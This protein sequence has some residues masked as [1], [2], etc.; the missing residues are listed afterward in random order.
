MNKPTEKF[1]AAFKWDDPFLLDDQL[2]EEERMVRDTAYAYSQEKLQPRVRE[3][4]EK[5][6]TDIAIFREM[7]EL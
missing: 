6:H 7:G 3:A 1:K 5:E 4:F 2:S